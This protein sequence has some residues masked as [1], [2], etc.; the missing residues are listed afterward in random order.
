MSSA[1]RLNPLFPF[2]ARAPFQKEI[3]RLLLLLLAVAS[4]LM[5]IPSFFFLVFLCAL[6]SNRRPIRNETA[7]LFSR[8]PTADFYTN[9]QTFSRAVVAL[10][11]NADVWL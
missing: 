11:Y 7:G 1:S 2:F 5:F 10:L 3:E 4:L 8:P 9:T 6:Y